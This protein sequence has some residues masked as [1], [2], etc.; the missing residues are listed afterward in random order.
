MRIAI[1]T[2]SFPPDVNGVAH[3][4]LRVAE[5]L[6][7][8]GHEPLV[9][10]PEPAPTAPGLTGA[11]PFPVVRVRS[12]PVP[13]YRGFRLGL[14][15]ANLTRAVAAHRPDLVHLASPFVLG[16]GGAAL[17][18]R[19]GVPIVAV[20]QTDVPGYAR[21]YRLGAAEATAWR[22]LRSVHTRADRTL[23]PST[24][25]AAALVEHGIGDVW[26][27][28]R[29][30]DAVRFDPGKRSER[31]RAALAPEGEIIVGYVGRLAT[32]KR[33]D[34]LA[35]TSRL[36]GVRVVVVGDGP[37][38]RRLEKQLPE[39]IF[40][41]ARHGEQ[42]ARLYAS[43]DLFVHTG[44]YETFGQTVQE[45][46]ASGL[47]VV[48]PAAG[49]PLDLVQPGVTGTL[50]PPGDGAA[51]AA[52]VAM[53][54]VDEPRRKEYGAA[55]RAYAEGRGWAVIGDELIGHYEAV[56]ARRGRL[57]AGSSGPGSRALEVAA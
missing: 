19:Y 49:G 44:P 50:V 36:P 26:L 31:L 39:V 47:P 56:L 23:A 2:E 18:E 41:G 37:A 24:T 27:W 46:L 5:H 33:V 57:A 35:Q 7:M 21:A 42:L 14:P 29:G 53:L 4:V 45:A 6:V 3:S 54:A 12:L 13:G 43:L 25:T 1:I 34:L 16:A 11:H 9:V 15:G 8:R 38:R 10:A 48:A 55:A 40:T 17:A 32:E 22:W 30:V 20:F 51:I 52:A 28:R